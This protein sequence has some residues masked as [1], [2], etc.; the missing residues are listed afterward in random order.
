M[1]GIDLEYKEDEQYAML[2][3][4]RP[5]YTRIAGVEES[6]LTAELQQQIVGYILYR[7]TP[8]LTNIVLWSLLSRTIRYHSVPRSSC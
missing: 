6:E 2:S 4:W 5:K 1:I 7:N 3:A 8:M